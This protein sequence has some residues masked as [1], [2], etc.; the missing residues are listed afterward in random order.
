M[1]S[2]KSDFYNF[3]KVGLLQFLILNAIRYQPGW[4]SK[5]DADRIYKNARFWN[6]KKETAVT[7]HTFFEKKTC[8][9]AVPV[10]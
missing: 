6:L 8:C 4:C 3:L 1:Y 9:V 7:I 2:L 10:H 5:R